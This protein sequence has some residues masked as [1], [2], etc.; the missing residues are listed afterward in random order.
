MTDRTPAPAPTSTS[1]SKSLTEVLST[2]LA[3]FLGKTA[4]KGSLSLIDQGLIS[5]TNFLSAIYL[6]RNIDPTAFGVYT[7]GFLLLHFLRAVQDG[8]VMQPISAIG[9]VLDLKE[10]RQYLSSTLSIQLVIA[11]SF[12]LGAAVLGQLLTALG[13]DTAGP[14]LY[15][16][17]LMFLTWPLQEFFRR[18]FYARDQVHLALAS[19]FIASVIRLA[20]LLYLG[21]RANLSGAD[22]FDAIAWGAVAAFIPGLWFA[23]AYLTKRV[24]FIGL[25]LTWKRNWEFGRWVLGG[26][27]ANW[28]ATEVYPIIT[29]GM[30]SFAA[31]GAYRA[32]QN[33]VA[34][35]HVLLRA[36][37]T[38][39]TPFTARDYHQHGAKGLLRTLRLIY[40]A[41]GL[42]IVGVLA[43]AWI[44]ADPLLELLYGQTYLAY[45]P[46]MLLMVMFYFLLFTYMPLQTGFKA[47][48]LTRPI[49]VANISAIVSMFTVGLLAINLWGVY[50]SILGQA[51][52]ALIAS[53]VLWRYWLVFAGRNKRTESPS[54]AVTT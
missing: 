20:Y 39:L 52:N 51:L 49:F 17:W 34:P 43:F 13:N 7:V 29:A 44:F 36:L 27:V 15:A 38:F 23:R 1:R 5:L 8:L 24:S 22:G 42:P 9:A 4:R 2:A 28:V 50:G 32:L 12:A 26:A 16:T 46:G 45:S 54:P 3:P 33:L 19:T 11:G 40:L 37:D 47:A 35:V 48:K 18:T 21:G 41:A 30:I 53:V 14:G 6:A 10:F 25:W 31:A